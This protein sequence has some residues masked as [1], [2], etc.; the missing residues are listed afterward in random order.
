MNRG[1][2][3]IVDFRSLNPKAGVRQ[4]LIVQNDRDNTRKSNTVVVQVTTNVS[5]I[6]IGTQ[7]LIQPGH[8]DWA[9]SGLRHAS[10]VNCANIYTIQQADIAKIIGSLSAA[11]MQQINA[12]LKEVLELS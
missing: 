3:V 11:T 5:R 1:H 9:I 4:A 10:A 8:P 7:V 6:G 2:L 12:C